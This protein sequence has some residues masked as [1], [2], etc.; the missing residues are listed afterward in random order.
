MKEATLELQWV[1]TPEC[2]IMTHALDFVIGRIALMKHLQITQRVGVL[3]VDGGY[4]RQL[5][6]EEPSEM[7]TGRIPLYVCGT[8]ADLGCGAIT[9]AI[10]RNDAGFIWRDFGF[11]ASYSETFS[12]DDYTER[13]GP[14]LF[15]EEPYTSLV[16][17]YRK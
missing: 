11:E 2:E 8:C 15:L 17:P 13:L 9:V 10:E 5:L 12:Q 7:P 4:A 1:E 6:L 3:S 16:S 14:F